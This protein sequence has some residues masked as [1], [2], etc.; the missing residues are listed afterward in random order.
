[1]RAAR[2]VWPSPRR[3]SPVPIFLTSSARTLV[4][5]VIL[6]CG[7]ITRW[8]GGVAFRVRD[9]TS[10]WGPPCGLT[11]PPS[12]QTEVESPLCSPPRPAGLEPEWTPATPAWRGPDGVLCPRTPTCR[13]LRGRRVLISLE[14][15]SHSH[16][17]WH[18]EDSE[19]IIHSIFSANTLHFK[20]LSAG[21][22]ELTS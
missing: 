18:K 11:C 6:S 10:H 21:Q 17:L 14:G 12:P 15:P 16:D 7:D 2:C 22:M 19:R 8:G 13:T 1:M 5:L 4:S 9:I 20:Y 3:P